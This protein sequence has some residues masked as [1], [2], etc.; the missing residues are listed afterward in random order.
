MNSLFMY[1][2]HLVVVDYSHLSFVNKYIIYTYVFLVDDT[3]RG[4]TI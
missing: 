4:S 3:E 1:G 2:I